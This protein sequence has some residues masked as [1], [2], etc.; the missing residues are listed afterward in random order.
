M[1]GIVIAH[2]CGDFLYARVISAFQYFFGMFQTDIDQ[3]TNRPVP[4]FALEDSRN[5]KG[6]L[7]Q[8]VRNLSQRYLFGIMV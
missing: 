2:L 1:I 6:A 4:R 3:V 7:I 5:I 8:G